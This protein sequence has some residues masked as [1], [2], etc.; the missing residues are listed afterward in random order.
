MNP[1]QLNNRIPECRSALLNLFAENKDGDTEM[2]KVQLNH[3]TKK[4]QHSFDK[5]YMIHKSCKGVD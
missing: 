4:W 2:K 1:V 3:C 5:L